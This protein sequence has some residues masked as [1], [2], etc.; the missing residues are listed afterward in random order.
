LFFSL[1][2]LRRLNASAM[3]CAAKIA[4]GKGEAEQG[5]APAL[6]RIVRDAEPDR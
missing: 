5:D 1:A 6:L 4:G 2:K 3:K